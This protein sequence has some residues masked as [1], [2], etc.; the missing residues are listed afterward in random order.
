MT[1]KLKRILAPALRSIPTTLTLLALVAVAVIGHKTHWKM[2]AAASLAS[3]EKPERDDWCMEHAVPESKC[4]VCRGREPVPDSDSV[5]SMT[6]PAGEAQSGLSE[7]DKKRRLI[8]FASPESVTKAGV[9]VVPAAEKVMDDTIEANAELGY[10]LTRYAQLASRVPG[11]V[12]AVMV[13]AGSRVKAGDVLA[14]IDSVE[15]G[16]AKAELLQAAAQVSSRRQTVERLRSSTA[17]GFRNTADLVQAEAELREAEI[18]L[19]GSR[20]AL[21]NLGLTPPTLKPGEVPN[22]SGLQLL[23][24]PDAVASGLDPQKTA[25]NLLPILSPLDGVIV[26]RQVV[27]GELVDAT[28]MLFAVADTSRMWVTASLSPSDAR[29]IS[30]GQAMEFTTDGVS[31]E[32]ARGQVTWVSTEVDEKTRTVQVRAEVPNP[33]GR[34]LAHSFGRARITL[35]RNDAAVVVPSAAVQWDSGANVVFVR[36]NDTVFLRRQVTVGAR[37]GAQTE[38]RSG[39]RTGERVAT[40]GSYVL[41]AQLNHEKLGAGCTDD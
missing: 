37:E 14:L 7:T 13:Q 11:S 28:K 39:L 6:P 41:A 23:G 26:K 25:A 35:S 17:A 24:L 5:A 8:Q 16:K 9:V 31:T 27:P 36:I 15:V 33:E 22:E 34:L 3:Q 30:I 10:D 4:L 12:T 1:N 20:Q 21:V 29:K 40:E 19:H 38:I 18:R 2:P 32:P